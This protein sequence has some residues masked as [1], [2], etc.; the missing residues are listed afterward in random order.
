MTGVN[1]SVLFILDRYSS[2]LCHPVAPFLILPPVYYQILLIA[3]SGRTVSFSSVYVA[4]SFNSSETSIYFWEAG[5]PI[6][7]AFPK[8]EPQK[9]APQNDFWGNLHIKRQTHLSSKGKTPYPLS[10]FPQN[11]IWIEN[12]A[13]SQIIFKLYAHPGCLLSLIFQGFL[14][15]VSQNKNDLGMRIDSHFKVVNLL[16]I[17]FLGLP[18]FAFEG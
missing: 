2:C 12:N 13:L 15:P 17:L 9:Q 6:L 11:G 3:R 8:A 1:L 4:I 18:R 16:F 14:S 7:R 10:I 5:I